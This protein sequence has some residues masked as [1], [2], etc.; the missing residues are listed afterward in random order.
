MEREIYTLNDRMGS[1]INGASPM[2]KLT[3][4]LRDHNLTIFLILVT[5]RPLLDCLQNKEKNQVLTSGF[6]D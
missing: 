4:L 6:E 3:I 1:E 2:V 5:W